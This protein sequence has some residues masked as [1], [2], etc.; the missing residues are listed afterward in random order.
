MCSALVK[1]NH[2]LRRFHQ[3]RFETEESDVKAAKSTFNEWYNVAT[4]L[5]DTAKLLLREYTVETGGKFISRRLLNPLISHCKT[6]V[7]EDFQDVFQQRFI[8]FLYNFYVD[9][10]QTLFPQTLIK[11]A[12]T[13]FE[14]WTKVESNCEMRFVGKNNIPKTVKDAIIKKLDNLRLEFGSIQTFKVQTDALEADLERDHKFLPKEF[15]KHLKKEEAEVENL[16]LNM[17]DDDEMTVSD[18]AEED[19]NNASSTA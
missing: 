18:A 6:K 14:M 11:T 16:E 2:F 5:T 8:R 10:D 1:I 12:I 15:S 19:E 7:T 3:E 9:N 13:Y 4:I 17:G